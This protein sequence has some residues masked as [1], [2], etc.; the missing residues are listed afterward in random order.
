[1][2]F[3]ALQ[4]NEQR[5]KYIVYSMAKVMFTFCKIIGILTVVWQWL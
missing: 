1:M 3:A 5:K 2:I 4:E